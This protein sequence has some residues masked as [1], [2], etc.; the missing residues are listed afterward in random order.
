MEIKLP[1]TQIDYARL[2]EAKSLFAKGSRA[3]S[4]YHYTSIGGLQGILS[5]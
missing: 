2:Q 3:K 1:K 5:S 4:V